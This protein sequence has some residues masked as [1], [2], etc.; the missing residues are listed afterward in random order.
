[1]ALHFLLPEI[2]FVLQ[3]IRLPTDTDGLALPFP[4]FLCFSAASLSVLNAR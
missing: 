2:I 3:W 1:M 4:K